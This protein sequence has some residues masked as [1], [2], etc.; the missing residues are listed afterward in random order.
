MTQTKTNPKWRL[1]ISRRI[2]VLVAIVLLLTVLA[3]IRLKNNPS[4]TPSNDVP[5]KPNDISYT[6]PSEEEKAETEEHKKNLANNQP[7]SPS[8][9]GEKKQVSPIITVLSSNE[10]RAYVPGVFEDGGNCTAVLSK[11]NEIISKNSTGFQDVN[12]TTCGPISLVG[13]LSMGAWTVIVKYLSP[14]AEGQS[15]PTTLEVR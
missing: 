7:P 6:P 8:I 5:S 12:K 13:E 10:I 1:F 15:Q 2:W 9:V 11:G 3:L 4:L 14:T